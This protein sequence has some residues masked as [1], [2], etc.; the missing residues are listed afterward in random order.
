MKFCSECGAADPGRFCSSCGY[1]HGVLNAPSAPPVAGLVGAAHPITPEVQEI[2]GWELWSARIDRAL[3][4]RVGCMTL[5]L[6]VIA[7]ALVGALWEPLAMPVTILVWVVSWLGVVMND[8][9]MA[10]CDA[11]MKRVKL[12]ATA[13]HHCGY[14]R[15]AL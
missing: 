13:C 14:S 1:E 2:S 5:L 12:G 4:F 7:G 10:K 3:S 8:E 6:G 9:Q 15:T 11:C